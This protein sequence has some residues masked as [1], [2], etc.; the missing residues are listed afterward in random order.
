MGLNKINQ[1]K[2]LL[3]KLL[4]FNY[5]YYIKN[6]IYLVI[7]ILISVIILVKPHGSVVGRTW[8]DAHEL[9]KSFFF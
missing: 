6:K 7:I 9:E 5:F 1:I 2:F 8:V 3:L 4:F